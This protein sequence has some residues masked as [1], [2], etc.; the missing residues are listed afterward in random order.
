MMSVG[1]LLSQFGD[2]YL[3]AL[4]TT[5]GLTVLCFAGALVL[6]IAITVMRI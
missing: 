3:Q 1:E 6:G 4:W 2:K 5:Y